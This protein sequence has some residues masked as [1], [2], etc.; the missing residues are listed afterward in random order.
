[1]SA[2]MT[3]APDPV[4]LHEKDLDRWDDDGGAGPEGSQMQTAASDVTDNM[5]APKDAEFVR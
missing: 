4:W 3:E 5:H 2:P 1:M